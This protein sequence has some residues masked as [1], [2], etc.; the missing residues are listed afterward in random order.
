M[1]YGRTQVEAAVRAVAPEFF[2]EVG[3]SARDHNHAPWLSFLFRR[4]WSAFKRITLP[5][6]VLQS[7]E[8]NS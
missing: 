5:E 7:I 1:P 2:M 3:P 6:V 4:T 8:Q